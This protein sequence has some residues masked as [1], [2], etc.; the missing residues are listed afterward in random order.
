MVGGKSSVAKITLPQSVAV[1]AVVFES[2]LV[3]EVRRGENAGRTLHD[4]FV[5]RRLEQVAVLAAD[6][7]SMEEHAFS[8]PLEARWKQER[9]G[10]AVLLQDPVSLTMY[11]AAVSG[12]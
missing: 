4:D 1:L 9:V 6:G 2:G 8:I 12:S 11:G 5:V 3:T 7:P 10:V